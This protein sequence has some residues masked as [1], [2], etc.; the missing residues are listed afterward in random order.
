M[1]TIETRVSHFSFLILRSLLFA[2]GTI[3]GSNGDQPG[4]V[5]L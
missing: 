1:S 5:F 2:W 4:T 3:A